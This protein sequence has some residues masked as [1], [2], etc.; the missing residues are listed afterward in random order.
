MR[1]TGIL[2][3]LFVLSSA[4]VASAQVPPA[5][6]LEPSPD[7]SATALSAEARPRHAVLPY[8]KVGGLIP[9]SQIGAGV[10]V[11]LGAGYVPPILKGRLAATLDLA[12]GQGGASD[13]VLDPRLGPDGG[14]YS[15]SL[16][17]RDLSLFVGPQ[18]FI[19]DPD[20]RIV[21]YAALGLELHFLQSVVEGSSAGS[22]LGENREV[23]TKAGFAV[24]GGAGY[25]LGPGMIIG[26]I[27]VGWAPLDHATTG[28]SHLGRVAILVGYQARLSFGR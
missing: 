10:A 15:Y 13:T 22:P 18:V 28:D 6:P 7:P 4:A 20:G 9:M 12:Y 23:S 17:Q 1:T 8:L 5:A 14:E 11:Q 25:R 24:R 2:S 27:A 21:P 16:T 19:L 26:E 3:W